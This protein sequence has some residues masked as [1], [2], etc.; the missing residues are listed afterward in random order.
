MHAGRALHLCAGCEA[1]LPALSRVCRLCATPLPG[2]DGVCG[3]CIRRPP[4]QDAAFAGFA[5]RFPIPR[6]VTGFKYEQQLHLGAVLGELFLH[7]MLESAPPRPDLL[8]PVP[9]HGRRLRERGF[10][11]SL[12]LART[13]ARGM[14]LPCAP[15]L[16][17][18]IRP[19]L[20]QAGLSP[21]QR[22]RNIR[23]VFAVDPS[24]VG[25]RV[26]I[27]DDVMT[28]G[29]TAGELVRALKTAGAARVDIWVLARAV[30]GVHDAVP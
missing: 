16:A 10:N 2:G 20:A 23:G 3:R 12:E 15:A 13:L 26:A 19:T 25:M 24:V 6:L 5:Y 21:V 7:R 8:L 28:T 30:H 27:V 29:S 17:R 22:R 18:R 4:P 9:L 14:D 11:Q 1:D